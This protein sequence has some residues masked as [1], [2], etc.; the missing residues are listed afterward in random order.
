[1]LGKGRRQPP[2]QPDRAVVFFDAV[3]AGD[4]ARVKALLAAGADV[5]AKNNDGV[6]ALMRA[7]QEG[8][9]QMVKLLKEAGA[10]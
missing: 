2:Q 1:M 4:L 9:Q 10:T 8:N 3:S 7:L 6:T 5:N